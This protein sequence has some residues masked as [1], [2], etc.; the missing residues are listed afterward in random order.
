MLEDY[1]QLFSVGLIDEN[2]CCM[3]HPVKEDVR[4][5]TKEVACMMIALLDAVIDLSPEEDQLSNEEEIL[6][7]FFKSVSERY[8]HIQKIKCKLEE[9]DEE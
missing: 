8:D 3:V 6:D 2:P 1:I 4:Y 7:F 5:G 9:E